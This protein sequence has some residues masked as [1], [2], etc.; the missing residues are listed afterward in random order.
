[1]KNDSTLSHP[2]QK[3]H[4]ADSCFVDLNDER[5]RDLIARVYSYILSD[6]WGMSDTTAESIAQH[7]ETTEP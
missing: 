4:T 7:D 6:Y 2:S 1:M 5:V 3:N